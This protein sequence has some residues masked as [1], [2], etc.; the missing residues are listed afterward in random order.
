G[1]EHYDR[2]VSHVTAAGADGAP[3]PV[4]RTDGPRWRLGGGGGGG[5]AA[6]PPSA[7]GYDVDVASM[8]REILEGSDASRARGGYLG[9]LGCCIFAYPDGLEARPI[10]LE[11]SA[12]A[13]WPVFTTLAP[14]APPAR[15]IARATARDFYSLADSQILLGPAFDADRV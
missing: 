5:V 2:W 3:L 7:I 15:G 14:S 10:L 9:L 13:D 4:E 11:I 6:A 1:V 12:P 8:E